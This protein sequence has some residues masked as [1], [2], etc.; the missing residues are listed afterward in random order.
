MKK[1][2]LCLFFISSIVNASSVLSSEELESITKSI[3]AEH[4][5][6]NLC[7]KG[8]NKLIGYVKTNDDYYAFCQKA[9]ESGMSVDK[10]QCKKSQA[11]RDFIDSN[12]N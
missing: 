8:F 3:C 2:F 5:D 6:P 12:A 11:L 7:I 1:I 4:P 9:T 10:E